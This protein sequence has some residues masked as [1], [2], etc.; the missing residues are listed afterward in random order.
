MVVWPR[1]VV[2]GQDVPAD[3]LETRLGATLRAQGFDAAALVMLG[4]VGAG[5]AQR[6]GFWARFV[7]LEAVGVW[8]MEFMHCLTGFDDLY[9]FGGNIGAFDEMGGSSGTHPT[10][11]TKAAIGWIDS[12]TI[13]TTSVEGSR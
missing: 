12:S 8:A 4:G 11:Y 13:L 5:I 10:A 3:G 6:A 9:P 7:M 1:Q 2:D